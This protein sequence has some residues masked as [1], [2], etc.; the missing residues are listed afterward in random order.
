MPYTIMGSS[1]ITLTR[2]W[3]ARPTTRILIFRMGKKCSLLHSVPIGSE[4]LVAVSE[5]F[6]AYSLPL[7]CVK[8]RR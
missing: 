7:T 4:S 1:D 5:V 6:E 3:A 8:Y 2:L